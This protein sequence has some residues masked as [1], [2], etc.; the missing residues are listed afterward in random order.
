M[1]VC[2]LRLNKRIILVSPEVKSCISQSRARR[3]W[4]SC[5]PWLWLAFY[6]ENPVSPSILATPPDCG[7]S[8]S[9][10][11]QSSH[12]P[13]CTAS[14][15]GL[16]IILYI[17]FFYISSLSYLDHHPFKVWTLLHSSK[18]YYRNLTKLSQ[19]GLWSFAGSL[20]G[21]QLQKQKSTRKRK[22]MSCNTKQ[23]AK[24]K[25]K[26]KWWNRTLWLIFKWIIYNELFTFPIV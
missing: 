19:W 16:S 11:H 14:T 5:L 24:V 7:R 8:R 26:L 18:H 22:A 9:S 25:R 1:A 23:A 12:H 6:A 17:F 2:Y 21:S 20:Q 15:Q 10:R 13:S 3:A 4:W